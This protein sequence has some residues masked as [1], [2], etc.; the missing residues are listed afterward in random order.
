M[1]SEVWKV[2]VERNQVWVSPMDYFLPR[3][4]GLSRYNTIK[5]K[6]STGR[7]YLRSTVKLVDYLVFLANL[8]VDGP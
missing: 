1:M 3:T 2:R 5:S 8:V 6:E 7:V 4:N